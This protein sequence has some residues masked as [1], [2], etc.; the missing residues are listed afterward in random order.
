MAALSL[1]TELGSIEVDIAEP[2]IKLARYLATAETDEAAVAVLRDVDSRLDAWQSQ[3]R[4]RGPEDGTVALPFG[5]ELRLPREFE[6][7]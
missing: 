2:V 7:R 4:E 3:R 5:V 6:R 1:E